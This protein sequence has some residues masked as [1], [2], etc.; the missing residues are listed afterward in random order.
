MQLREGNIRSSK[1]L[2]GGPL[3]DIGIYCINA[4][5]YVF[6]NEPLETMAFASKN[7]DQRFNEINEMCTV[8]LRFPEDCLAT[9]TCSFGAAATSRYQVVGTKGDIAVDPAYEYVQ[10]LKYR[11]TVDGKVMEE[12]TILKHDQFAPELIH[13]SEC[14]LKNLEPQ[15]SGEEGLADIR[16]INAI[17]ESI[18]SGKAIRIDPVEPSSRPGKENVM[19]KP[20]LKKEPLINV[21]SASIN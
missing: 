17:E 10:P 1:D 4:A 16:I 14:I 19:V 18:S 5:R 20:A 9:F 7:D 13:F 11:V 8:I 15:P 6:R 2:G 21:E 3:K 12:K